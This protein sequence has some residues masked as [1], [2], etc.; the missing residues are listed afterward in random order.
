MTGTGLQGLELG[1]KLELCRLCSG[2]ICSE[3]PK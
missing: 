2:F 3:T 1:L